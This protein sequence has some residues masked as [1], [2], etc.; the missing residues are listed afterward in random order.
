MLYPTIREARELLATALAELE[1]R[2]NRCS[3]RASR[4][5]GQR[6]VSTRWPS[7]LPHFD[8]GITHIN[9]KTPLAGPLW[10]W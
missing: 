9:S 1:D 10:E 5:K 3:R 2:W 4:R 8:S 6:V 7:T